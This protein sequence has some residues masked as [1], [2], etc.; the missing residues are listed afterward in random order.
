MTAIMDYCLY[1]IIGLGLASRGVAYALYGIFPVLFI[2][3]KMYETFVEQILQ[4][5]HERKTMNN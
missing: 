1:I 3:E 5:S 4:V 2:R